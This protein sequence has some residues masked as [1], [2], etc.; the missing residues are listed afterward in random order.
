MKI[1]DMRFD[2]VVIE[3][4]NKM[5]GEEFYYYKFD[6]YQ[7]LNE[8]HMTVEF[9]VAGKKYAL[10]NQ[11]EVVDY[12]G[13]E[14]NMTVMHFLNDPDE[15]YEYGC[16]HFDINAKINKVDIIDENQKL[17]DKKGNILYDVYLTRGLIFYIKHYELSFQKQVI[18]YVPEIIPDLGFLL[19]KTFKPSTYY[20]KKNYTNSF[21]C[22]QHI[23]R[24]G[25]NND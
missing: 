8:R 22:V 2:D 24:L 3:Q 1:I 7:Y 4:L 20:N 17:L 21:K 10:I 16:E 15:N 5:I 23:R 14:I 6:P 9:N 19:V 25:Y 13:E 12:F 11:E 18:P